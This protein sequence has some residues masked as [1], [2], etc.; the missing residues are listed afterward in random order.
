MHDV[1][2]KSGYA[3]VLGS[4]SED[5]ARARKM[6]LTGAMPA[7]DGTALARVGSVDVR[8]VEHDLK[9]RVVESKLASRADALEQRAAVSA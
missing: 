8:A 7:A 9:A 4:V 3:G 2:F 5:M 1:A 6:L